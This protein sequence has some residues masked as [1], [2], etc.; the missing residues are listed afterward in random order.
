LAL[1]ASVFSAFSC[2]RSLSQQPAVAF[3][4][5]PIAGLVSR[6]LG[7]MPLEALVFCTKL[8]PISFDIR[9][10]Q[11]LAH[12]FLGI[13]MPAAASRTRNHCFLYKGIKNSGITGKRYTS[14]AL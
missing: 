13:Q 6:N 1:R 10:G 4:A 14:Y 2:V 11:L 7:R 9:A 8:R 3:Q 5:D 12:N